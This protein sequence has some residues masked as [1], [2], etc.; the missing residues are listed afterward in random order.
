MEEGDE[1]THKWTL[2]VSVAPDVQT[3]ETCE[4]RF[5][6]R[7]QVFTFA[8]LLQKFIEKVEVELHPT[9]SPRRVTLSKPPYSLTR[10]GTP[11]LKLQTI[12]WFVAAPTGWGTFAIGV[13]VHFR[14]EAGG[15]RDPLSVVHNLNFKQP[16]TSTQHEVSS[17][18]LNSHL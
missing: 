3:D 12:S 16:V 18:V 9:F 10:Y 6:C 5:A 17:A 7:Y 8:L 13:R 4:V 11:V 1:N 15:R 14:A 2:F